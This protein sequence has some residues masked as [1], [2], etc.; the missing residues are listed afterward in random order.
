MEYS[1]TYTDLEAR[2]AKIAEAEALG[3]RMVNDNFDPL[4]QPGD[5]PYGTLIFT[6]EPPPPLSPEEGYSR[7]LAETFN[8]MHAQAIQ[9]YKNWD[10][11]SLA[12][13]DTILKNLLLWV[14]WKDGRLEPGVL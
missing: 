14:L 4:W 6:D 9:A 3:L 8:A 10:S 11:L 13:K 12:Q 7:Q 5:E 1:Y 2:R